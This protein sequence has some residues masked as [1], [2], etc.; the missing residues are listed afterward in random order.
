MFILK[1]TKK[2]KQ[3]LIVIYT[4]IL[5]IHKKKLSNNINYNVSGPNTT[6]DEINETVMFKCGIIPFI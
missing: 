5:F 2:W 6:V 1:I 4:Y 3:V